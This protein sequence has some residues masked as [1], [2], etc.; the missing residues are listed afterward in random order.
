MEI[1]TDPRPL[2][3]RAILV[4]DK[5]L[6]LSQKSDTAP[7]DPISKIRRRTLYLLT[8]H[9]NPYVVHLK[10]GYVR[11]SCIWRSLKVHH[12]IHLGNA[13]TTQDQSGSFT[14]HILYNCSGVSTVISF[15]MGSSNLLHHMVLGRP[16]QHVVFL[17]QIGRSELASVIQESYIKKGPS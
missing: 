16:F 17:L 13:A 12:R 10:P 7:R 1:W 3:H 4:P 2:I 11:C 5:Y 6:S 8:S 9:T 14:S 15:S